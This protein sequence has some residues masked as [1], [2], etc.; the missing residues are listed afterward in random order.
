M[1][2]AIKDRLSNMIRGFKMPNSIAFRSTMLVGLVVLICLTIM[3]AVVIQSIEQHFE[4]QD[5]DELN[6]VF[7]A[8][9]AKLKEA[10]DD[11]KPPTELLV[12]AVSGHHGVYYHI[13]NDK[14]EVLFSSS[15]ADFNFYPANSPSFKT[16]TPSN[17]ILFND[18]KHMLR[19]TKLTTNIIRKEESYSYTVIVASN[20]E[21]H[22]SYMDDFKKTL[23]LITLCAAF[24]TIVAAR[25][26]IYRGHAPLR[27]LSRKIETI[28]AEH[29]DARLS[30]DAVPSELS[31]LVSSFNNMIQKLEEGFERLSF[32]S[33]DIAHELRTPITN[34]T[35]QTQV[36]LSQQRTNKEYTDI[37]YSHL[38]E[39]ERMSKM[40]GDMLLLAQ[41]EHGLVKP[42]KD[43]IAV[44]KEIKDLC[45]YFELLADE[46]NIS[47]KL[48]GP[49][50]TTICDKTMLRQALSNLISNAIRYSPEDDTILVETTASTDSISISIT[51]HGNEIPR[52]HLMRLFDRFYRTDPSRKRDGHGAGLGLTIAKSLVGINGGDIVAESTKRCTWFTVILPKKIGD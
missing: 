4:E 52:E 3:H 34:L 45:E 13:E 29:L 14:G 23:W 43:T 36:M 6:E 15:D 25:Y 9:N 44:N 46:K 11:K 31:V 35:T 10:A 33:A 18:T 37:L 42:N 40:V 20:M 39:Y 50:I 5:A 2:V 26:A 38:E 1:G 47:L 19:A 41:T 21:F 8:V 24:V 17:L 12:E 30:T 48:T 51:N 28:S 16:I 22:M 32:F 7:L 49:T 27:K